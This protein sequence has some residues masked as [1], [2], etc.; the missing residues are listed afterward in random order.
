[1]AMPGIVTLGL[2]KRHVAGTWSAASLVQ[3]G[4][5]RDPISKLIDSGKRRCLM[6]PRPAEIISG[7]LAQGRESGRDKKHKEREQDNW[8]DQAQKN[9]I[10]E[11]QYKYKQEEPS[12]EAGRA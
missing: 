12:R 3:L 7:D 2:G 11:W 9:F 10:Q 5:V 4:I 8:T 6:L 1:M